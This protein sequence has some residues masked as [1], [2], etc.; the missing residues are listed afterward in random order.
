MFEQLLHHY[1]TLTNQFQLCPSIAMA[2]CPT[3]SELSG[4]LNEALSAERARRVSVHVD[5]CQRCQARLDKLTNDTDGA[6]A[7]YKELS[8]SR[9]S[10]EPAPEAGTLVLGGNPAVR[11]SGLPQVP[12]FELLAEI[13]RGVTGVVYRARHERLNRL[14]ALKL[15]L[16]GS[17]ADAHTRKQFFTEVGV[18]A[19][20]RQAQLARVFEVDTYQGPGGVP[21]PY[22]ASELL[23]GGSVAQS[24]E[25]SS[26][27]PREAAELIEGVARA[28]QAAHV[29]GVIHG[30]LKPGNILAPVGDEQ[31]VAPKVVDFGLGRFVQTGVMLTETG[32]MFGLSPYTAPEQAVGDIG[33]R[34]DVYSLGAIL[35][36]CLTGSP[37]PRRLVGVPRD[38]AAV[39][40]RCLEKDTGR[41]Y[42]GVEELA[43]DL[44]RFRENRPT[45]AR[46][47]R[48]HEL[49]WLWAKRNP[50]TT[51]I[52]LAIVVVALGAILVTLW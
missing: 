6:V 20:L 7:R 32:E 1:R 17:A 12:G 41:R 5:R 24:I 51:G 37:P 50:V 40:E 26:L 43:D 48:R 49:A 25:H 14:V 22:V 30:N 21:I 31:T 28:L 52:L 27:A 11:L 8:P 45:T 44:R 2:A 23:E 39:I 47:L 29:K 36:E 34:S 10:I 35:C 33:P 38:L 16:A 15:V 4:F 13:G 18:I 46:P 42:P 19:R 9:L 3:D